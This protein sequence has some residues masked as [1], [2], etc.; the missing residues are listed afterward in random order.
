ML[1]YFMTILNILWPFGI[2]YGRLE[3]FVVIWY[4]FSRFGK[5]NWDKSGNPALNVGENMGYK[6]RYALQL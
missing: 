6:K 2:I 3:H 5:L 4:I 1:V